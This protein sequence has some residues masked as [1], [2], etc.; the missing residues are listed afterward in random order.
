MFPVSSVHSEHFRQ[1]W[2]SCFFV[3]CVEKVKGYVWNVHRDLYETRARGCSG[4]TFKHKHTIKCFKPLVFNSRR[5]E[6]L[7]LFCRHSSAVIISHISTEQIWA[8]SETNAAPKSSRWRIALSIRQAA[9]FKYKH[10]KSWVHEAALGEGTWL[11]LQALVIAC[12]CYH[13]PLGC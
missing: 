13:R 2:L 8:C 6:P 9:R 4:Q 11:G 12:S 10:M 7:R 3:K 5:P 1:Q